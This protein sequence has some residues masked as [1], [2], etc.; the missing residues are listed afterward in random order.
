MLW[1]KATTYKFIREIK[2]LKSFIVPSGFSSATK[3]V[4]SPPELRT[5]DPTIADD[6]FAGRLTFAGRHISVNTD[7][8]SF[9]SIFD[10]IPPSPAFAKELHAFGWL[11]HVCARHNPHARVLV[12]DWINTYGKSSN[13]FVMRPSVLSR[14]LMSFV[15]QAPVLLEGAEP[16][17]YHSFMASISF[18]ASILDKE[19]RL[20][21][22]QIDRLMAWTALNYF[23]QCLNVSQNFLSRAEAGLL[24]TLKLEI[25]PDGGHISRNPHIL[26]DA[27]LDLLP[28]QQMF[29]ARSR[30]VP[31][32][33]PDAI[34]RILGMLKLLRHT[35]GSIG[36]FN[37]MSA[38]ETGLVARILPYLGASTA[39]LLDASYSGYQRLDKNKSVLLVDAG[40]GPPLNYS[41]F[42]HAGCLSFEFSSGLNRIIVNCGAPLSGSREQVSQSRQTA[43]H[44]ALTINNTSSSTFSSSYSKEF[45]TETKITEGPVHLTYGR[46]IIEDG[47]MLIARH[48]G[49]LTNFGLVYQRSFW[50]DKTG[51]RL[52]GQDMLQASQSEDGH[53]SKT[54]TTNTHQFQKKII[55][56]NLPFALRFH[57][58]PL[59]RAELNDDKTE[60]KLEMQ[61]KETWKFTASGQPVEIEN[62]IYFAT[63]QGQQKTSQIV[64]LGRASISTKIDWVLERI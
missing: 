46:Q 55:P 36:V 61:N 32:L 40:R 43:A 37:G 1:S 7:G 15:S 9:Q 56:T 24:K 5:V 50:L 27:V 51:L 64:I 17:F 48:D 29:V 62:S 47:D 28:L 26:L 45:D 31:V 23:A 19:L 10:V 49:Y 16:E 63:A 13:G 57:L 20:G 34:N 12:D 35:D 54:K 8:S 4:V 3:I 39:P 42:A 18:Q 22:P 30:S 59:V 21:L 41:S 52:E 11:R 25:L 38:T 14:R 60:V 33:I 6:I 2:R 44:S 58:H 53:S